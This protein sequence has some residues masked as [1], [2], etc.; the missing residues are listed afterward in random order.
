MLLRKVAVGGRSGTAE[1]RSSENALFSSIYDQVDSRKVTGTAVKVDLITLQQLMDEAGVDR[2]DL[3]KV[4]CEGAEHEIFETMTAQVAGRID[5][6]TME[7]HRIGDHSIP[8][9]I[10]HLTRLGYMVVPHSDKPLY[11]R[12]HD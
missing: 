8:Q 11:A 5:Q 6:I 7:V 10:G 9:L 12:R 1:L 3:L 2:C 4:D